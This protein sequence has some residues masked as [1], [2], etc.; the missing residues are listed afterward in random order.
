[1]SQDDRAEVLQKLSAIDRKVTQLR[2]F[3]AGAIAL[4][5]GVI[6]YEIA[7]SLGTNRFFGV[8][9]GVVACVAVGYGELR[10]MR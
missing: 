10:V 4:G 2:E 3:V 9:I 8:V 6:G 7:L 1:M 5:A